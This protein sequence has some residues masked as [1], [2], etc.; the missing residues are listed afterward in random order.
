MQTISQA[1]L[2]RAGALYVPVLT[3]LGGGIWHRMRP[4]PRVFA[5]TLLSMLWT[6][7]S[8]LMLQQLNLRA[9]WWSYTPGSAAMLSAMPLE[10]YLS[11]AVLWGAVPS[12]A[13]LPACAAIARKLNVRRMALPFAA[14]VLVLVDLALMPACKDAVVLGPHWFAGEAVAVVLV[15]LPALALA[16]YTQRQTHLFVRATLQALLAAG[17]FLYWIPKLTA[18]LSHTSLRPLPGWRLLLPFLLLLALPGLGAVLEFAQCGGG[19]P[20]P[21]DPPARLVSSGIFRY[22]ANPMQLSTT[23]LM[24]AWA[25]LFRNAWL[26]IP[27]LLSVIYCAGLAAWDEG[28]DLRVRFGEPW[29][30][31][32]RSVHDWRLRLAP[33]HAGEP[34]RLYYAHSCVACSELGQWLAGQHARG[35]ELLAA[36]SLAQAP[37]RLLYVAPTGEQE[38]GTRA[39]ARALEHLNL[40]YALVGTLLRLPGPAHLVQLVMDVSGFDAQT[41]PVSC[42]DEKQIRAG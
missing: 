16:R 36:E 26:L 22:V 29:L 4:A 34:A 38:H 35:L 11:W 2:T 10:L 40:G 5:A 23:L 42:E 24:L 32:R 20:I 33:Y 30:A 25:A 27:A 31:Y 18:T 21:Y 13:L 28:E 6:L 8:L 9:H 3:A 14:T 37:R 41:P 17:L 1:E 39:F 12:L 7:P 15:L 19:T